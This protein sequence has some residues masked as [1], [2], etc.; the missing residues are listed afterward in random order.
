VFPAPTDVYF[1]DVDVVE[2]DVVFVGPDH[3]DRIEPGLLRSAPDVIVEVS[4]PSIREIEL[5]RKKDLYEREGIPEYWYVDLEA[6]RVEI[7][8][9]TKER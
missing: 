7:Y 9:L 5:R 4:S 6:D 8:R 1:S 2:P 3:A